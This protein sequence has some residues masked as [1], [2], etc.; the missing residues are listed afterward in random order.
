MF[1]CYIVDQELS[2]KFGSE[3]QLEKETRDTNE[4]PPHVKEFLD[5]VPFTLHDTP[6]QEEFT[7]T[8]TFGD[9]KLVLEYKVETKITDESNLEFE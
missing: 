5:N 2:A 3:L 8:R 6:G 1:I 7:L 9:E 4:L